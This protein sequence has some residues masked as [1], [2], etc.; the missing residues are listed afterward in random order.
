LREWKAAQGYQEG[1]IVDLAANNQAMMAEQPIDPAMQQEAQMADQLVQQTILAILGRVD[2]PDVIIDMFID[3][4][5]QEAYLALRDEVLNSVVPGANTEGLIDGPGDGMSDNV[6]GMIGDQQRV[7]TSQ[8]E[9]IIP[10]DAV[11]GLGNG[12]TDAGA[13]ALDGMVAG[14]RE[15]RTGTDIQPEAIIPEEFMPA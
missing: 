14:I 9:Y 7:A 3:E 10:A 8:G 12:S 1:G 15:A 11:S 13:G 5:G 2:D 6:P 4:F